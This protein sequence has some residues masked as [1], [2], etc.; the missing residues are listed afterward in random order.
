ML[1]FATDSVI[2]ARSDTQGDY[3]CFT[4]SA[5][6]LWKTSTKYTDFYT[7]IYSSYPG[8]RYLSGFFA[9]HLAVAHILELGS[10]KKSL[11]VYI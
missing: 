11:Q 1:D 4:T 6:E 9:D 5:G 8:E 2:E 10:T 3:V 7:M